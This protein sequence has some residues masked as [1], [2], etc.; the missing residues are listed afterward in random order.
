[1]LVFVFY[2]FVPPPMLFNRVH[3]ARVRPGRARRE[4]AALEAAS[5]SGAVDE[6][7]EAAAA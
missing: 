5:S 2:L 1:M 4:Y 6:R 7:R 3:D